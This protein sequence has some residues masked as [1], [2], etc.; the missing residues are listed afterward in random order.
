MDH[1]DHT[2]HWGTPAEASAWAPAQIAWFGEFS[3]PTGGVTVASTLS[4]GVTVSI[5]RTTTPGIAHNT[6]DIDCEALLAQVSHVLI[7]HQFLKK[8]LDPLALTIES[9]IPQGEGLGEQEAIAGAILLALCELY[10]DEPPTPAHAA[11]MLSELFP[12]S[13][14]RAVTMMRSEENMVLGMV[15]SDRAVIPLGLHS[16]RRPLTPRLFIK[17]PTPDDESHRQACAAQISELTQFIRTACQAF[18][19]TYLRELP[20]APK[21]VL[22]WLDLMRRT[23]PERGLPELDAATRWL[24]LVGRDSSRARNAVSELRARHA[25]VAAHSVVASAVELADLCQIPTP[26]QR[27][28]LDHMNFPARP[29]P[30][31]ASAVLG[32]PTDD[33][34]AGWQVI[35]AWPAGP[36]GRVSL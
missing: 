13:W 16:D 33:V 6:T 35:D 20:H 3:S 21:R 5:H 8:E 10:V 26:T 28:A 17:T 9:S 14:W 15:H 19:V 2:Q 11:D 34:P 24:K 4:A 23:H 31:G 30:G 25:D 12:E 1:I 29:I 18:G 7:S 36:G 22:E 32:F 27:D